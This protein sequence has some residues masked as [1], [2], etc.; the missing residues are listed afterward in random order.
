MPVTKPKNSGPVQS[1]LIADDDTVIL[2]VLARGFELYGFNVFT[3][4]NGIDCWNLFND[5][6]VDIVLTDIRMPGDLDGAELACRIREQSPGTTIAVITGGDGEVGSSLLQKGI[7]DYFFKKP[8]SLIH[9]CK[10][11]S[12]IS[13]PGEPA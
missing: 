4:G 7:A 5:L 9:L 8:C 13:N 11:L 1:I 10:T 2:D 12:G 3:A 6:Q